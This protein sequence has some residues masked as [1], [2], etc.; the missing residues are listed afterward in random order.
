MSEV[1]VCLCAFVRICACVC[2]CG[3]VCVCMC[4]PDVEITDTLFFLE[5]LKPIRNFFFSTSVRPSVCLSVCLDVHVDTITFERVSGF[6]QNFV[7][8]FYV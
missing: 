1:C 2:L 4:V 7:G 6:K 8:V 3:R 5:K